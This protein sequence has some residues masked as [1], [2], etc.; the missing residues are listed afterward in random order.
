MRL[1]RCVVPV[2]GRPAMIIGR[3]IFSSSISR[4]KA[5]ELLHAEP[6][7][8]ELNDEMTGDEPP[9]G[10]ERCFGPKCA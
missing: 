4:V 2:R 8:E 5:I 7:P 3:S 1:K 10:G 9:E 6:A